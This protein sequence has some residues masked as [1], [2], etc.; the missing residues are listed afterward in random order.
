MTT[1]VIIAAVFALSIGIAVLWANPVRFTN[2]ACSATALVA[3]AQLFFLYAAI[4]AGM[5]SA[6]DDATSSVP[7][8]RVAA[9]ISVFLPWMIWILKE[10]LVTV[11][12]TR[13][14]ILRRSLP[15]LG[16]ASVLAVL[17]FTNS[18]IPSDSSLD[19][20][21]R[22]PNYTLVNLVLA[23][24]YAFLTKQGLAQTRKQAGIKR[25]EM[26]FLVLNTTIG[27]FLSVSMAFFGRYSDIPMLR[28]LSPFPIISACAV[29][30]WAVTYHRIFD[31]RQVF[32][33][34]AQRL[35]SVLFLGLGIFSISY[36]LDGL[37]SPPIALLLGVAV[38]SG[39]AFW[40]DRRSR[41]WL[42]LGGERILSE[43]RRSVIEL[44]RA[45]PHPEKLGE[46]FETFLCRQCQTSRATLLF[47]RGDAYTAGG[48]EFA[49][50]RPGHIPLYEN[51]WA[52][53]ETLLRRRPTPNLDDLAKF[54]GQHSL[55]LVVAAPRGSSTPTLFI[56]LGVKDNEWP[57]TY[58]EVQRLQNIAELMDNILTRSRLN[59]QA[60]MRAKMEHL[61]MISRG[62]AHDLN[63]LIT[64]ISSFLVHTDNRFPDPS[65]E[66]EVH[67]AAKRSVRIMGDY[68][69]EALFFSD[70]L[71]PNFEPVDL[72][73]LFREVC[74]LTASRAARQD[75]SVTSEMDYV[76]S[77]IG[78]AVL[79]QR[80]LINLVGN[81]IDA[82][83]RDGAV[84]LSA[85]P[86][87]SGWFCLRV[88][89]RGCGIAP[90]NLGR[91]FDPYFTT[92]K[93]GDD[94]RGFGLGLTICQKI[95]HLHSGTISIHSQ[96]GEGTTVTIDL[97]VTQNIQLLESQ[98]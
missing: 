28:R 10:S 68:V 42:G 87:R 46:R 57:F 45:E 69:R 82:S 66:H 16:I 9:S 37:I 77:V 1:L 43:M 13:I 20:V 62:L 85:S 23:I 63:N 34:L 73:H 31:V 17:C 53:P 44:A 2:Q 36:S 84:T 83:S 81:A 96:L 76:G 47:D 98:P 58:P 72:N 50:D 18:F 70:R 65:P 30:A 90:E 64:P 75:I 51:G 25:I 95:V 48:L 97:P 8:L 5:V 26:Q 4:K 7:M 91:I 79:L 3:A 61:A 39:I 74:A 93:Y 88:T 27:A 19:N 11:G 21:R 38:F 78:D 59:L 55:G 41:E 22:G 15:W 60:A 40:L 32:L 35:G 24:A 80:V 71:T 12:P 94:V 54:L 29:A 6:N 52:T 49:K 67:L 86:G 92:K 14:A 33:S 56:A 89:D